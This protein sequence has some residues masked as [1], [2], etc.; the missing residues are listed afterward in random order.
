MQHFSVH[1]RLRNTMDR[2]KKDRNSKPT[3][4][5]S[6]ETAA[7]LRLIPDRQT[8]DS[9]VRCYIDTFETTYRILH[10]PTFLRQYESIWKDPPEFTSS[11]LV[12][13][14]LVMAVV[15]PVSP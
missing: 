9:L 5:I 3:Q 6:H 15:N 12:V 2:F 1:D 7:L 8:T 14:L 4:S 10:V 13:L 11:F